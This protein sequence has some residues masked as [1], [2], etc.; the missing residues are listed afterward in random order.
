MTTPFGWNTAK[1]KAGALGARLP[2]C[3]ELKQCHINAPSSRIKDLW[4]PAS[5]TNGKTNDWCQV[6]NGLHDRC[7]KQYNYH[8]QY[9]GGIPGWTNNDPLRASWK[10]QGYFYAK[11]S[12]IGLVASPWQSHVFVWRGHDFGCAQKHPAVFH[13]QSLCVARSAPRGF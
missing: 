2:T 8:S 6:S 7:H 11:A 10:F 12:R 13:L 5:H 1:R 9:C 3:A 4:M